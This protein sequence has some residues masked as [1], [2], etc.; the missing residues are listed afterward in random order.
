MKSKSVFKEYDNIIF[1]VNYYTELLGV[2]S[3]LSENQLAIKEAG[4]ERKNSEY[5][6]DVLDYFGEY[7]Y[8]PVTLMLE[9]FSEQYYF[10]YDAPVS[11]FLH[12]EHK[13]T[14]NRKSLCED[15]KLIDKQKFNDFIKSI[16]EFAEVS[17][18]ND[19]YRKHKTT[20]LKVIDNF[21]DDYKHYDPLTFLLTFLDIK[22]A[23]KYIVNFMLGI[24]N[25]NYG[26]NI[27]NNIYAN[28]RPYRKSR[29]N[30]FPDFSYSPIYYTTLILHEFAHAFINPLIKGFNQIINNIN[31]SK[32]DEILERFDYGDNLTVYIA[33]TV[34]RAIE[35]LYVKQQFP[36]EHEAYIQDN[37]KEGFILIREVENILI[38]KNKDSRLNEIINV[39]L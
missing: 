23:N 18:Y 30:D 21:I 10:N 29:Y 14:I 3:I 25:G 31:I 9:L 7:K 22:T 38:S 8:N 34:I 37:V 24:T 4:I 17:N 15:R 11:L 36:T 27:K 16:E 5:R 33:E 6:D 28:L 39:F 12:L 19:F 2:L 32:Y 20:Y 35:C 1:T 26:V 13:N